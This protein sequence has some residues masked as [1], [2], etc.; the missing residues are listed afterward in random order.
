VASRQD[1]EANLIDAIAQSAKRAD[2]AAGSNNVNSVGTWANAT[3]TLAQAFA[4]VKTGKVQ[5]S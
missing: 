2:D 4:I 3:L 5:A 1:A